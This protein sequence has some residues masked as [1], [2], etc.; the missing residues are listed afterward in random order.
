MLDPEA[1]V[2]RTYTELK[3]E[4][5]ELKPEHAEKQANEIFLEGSAH[6]EAPAP[7]PLVLHRRVLTDRSN[8]D[9]SWSTSTLMSPWPLPLGQGKGGCS[10][11]RF[12]VPFPPLTA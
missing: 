6:L 1:R 7:Q 2:P 12:D 5:T 9:A 3:S 10:T 4:P 11:Y 8:T